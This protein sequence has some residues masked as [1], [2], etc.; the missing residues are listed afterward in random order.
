MPDE[1]IATHVTHQ[2]LP[3]RRVSPSKSCF[4][5]WRAAIRHDNDVVTCGIWP[6]K[7]RSPGEPQ[8]KIATRSPLPQ[9]FTL[10]TRRSYKELRFF[11]RAFK[12]ESI[13]ALFS[14]VLPIARPQLR[15]QRTRECLFGVF[16]KSQTSRPSEI[17]FCIFVCVVFAGPCG[18]ARTREG[19]TLFTL[20]GSAATPHQTIRGAPPMDEKEQSKGV[21]GAWDSRTWT[22]RKYSFR[23]FI[24]RFCIAMHGLTFRPSKSESRF[25]SPKSIPSADRG[26]ILEST[27][28]NS[29]RQ[30]AK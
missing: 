13:G 29:R 4:G 22:F 15:F 18:M 14:T 17:S 3:P 2:N 21:P 12:N 5:S 8:E 9:P 28:R 11:E 25:F 1:L 23:I 20:R 30:H 6:A 24:C 16:E 26:F 19:K 7:A 27:V 10:F